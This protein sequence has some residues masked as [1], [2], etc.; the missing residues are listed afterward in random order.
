[1]RSRSERVADLV[2]GCRIIA[3][4]GLAE[5]YTGHISA[6][7]EDGVLVPAHRHDEGYGL[8]SVTADSVIQ[9][10]VDGEP[11]EAGVEPP[12][13]FTIHS[14]ILEARPDV[15]SVAHAHPL[16]AT[17]LSMTGTG[18]EPSSL[19]AALLGGSVPVFDPGPKLIHTD[20]EGAALAD[21]LGDG[22]AALIRGHG[23]VTVGGS[24]AAATTRLYVLERAARLQYVA[25]QF[26][27]ADPTAE[28]FDGDVL[29][30][31]GEG[32]LEEAFEY[33]RRQY[34]DEGTPPSIGGR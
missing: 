32:F 17:G 22:M 30:E 10:S 8:E 6:R 31:S 15:E 2:D 18:I 9:V 1:M 21:A 26:G 29:A 13:E 16:Y 33:L 20:D 19:D 27:G 4:A 11:R 14:G 25:E 34:A 23:V 28:A 7:T 24:I 3:N 12:S 5:L